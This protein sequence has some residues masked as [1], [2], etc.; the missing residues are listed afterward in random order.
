MLTVVWNTEGFHIIEVF[1]KG[2]TFGIDHPGQHILS[3]I[4]RACPVRSNHR[5]VVHAD[6]ARPHASK[7]TRELMEKNPREEPLS[8][9]FT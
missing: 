3:E 9:G 8:F 2:A 5:L 6:Q 4:L 1:P 7:C